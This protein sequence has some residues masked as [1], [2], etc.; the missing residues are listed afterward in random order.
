MKKIINFI[1]AIL[2]CGV[3]F[4]QISNTN[5]FKIGM[6]GA[7]FKEKTPCFGETWTTPL[8]NNGNKTS[9]LNVYKEDGF[10]IFQAYIPSEWSTPTGIK[11]MLSLAEANDLKICIHNGHYYKPYVD[12]A[13]NY[14][15]GNST[16]EYEDCGYVL[17]PCEN[18]YF[19]A[20]Y[21]H[22]RTNILDHINNIY[23]LPKYSK[24]IWGIVVAEESSIFHLFHSNPQC[25]GNIY[26]NPN[27]FVDVELPPSN[28][29][30]ASLYYKNHL[31][32]PFGITHIKSIILEANHEKT[33]FENTIDV[34][35]NHN[36]QEYIK[37]LDKN[38][39]RDLFFESSYTM[40][41]PRTKNDH[42]MDMY[43]NQRHYLG[44][45]KTINYALKYTK[46]VHKVIAIQDVDPDNIYHF[47]SDL[48]IK[49]ANWL[50]FQTYTSIIHGATG[51]WFWSIDQS[52]DDSEDN[53]EEGGEKRWKGS[54]ATLPNRFD[55][56]YFPNHYK[57][58]ISNLAKELRYLVNKNI[59]STDTSN[60]IGVK[61]DEADPMCIVP[62]SNIYIP[63][64]L[65]I[66]RQNENYGL[67]YT[68]RSNGT[69]VY[70]I[71]SNP[72][73][74]I[75]NNV[76]LNFSYCAN[77]VIRNSSSVSVLFENN[78]NG[79]SSSNYKIDR[80]SGID[81]LNNTIVSQYDLAIN[82]S[83]RKLFLSFGP[84]DVKVIK[85]NSNPIL[86]NPLGWKQE[87]TNNGN[88]YIGMKKIKDNDIFING[89]FDG[90]GKD[91]LLLIEYNSNSTSDNITLL[92]QTINDD[93]EMLWSNYGS[94]SCVLYPY[95]N[96]LLVGDFDGDG[97]DELIGNDFA[98]TTMFKFDN[99][100]WN[101]GWSDYGN[102]SHPIRPYKKLF[103]V[104]DFD[105]N[106]K[107][108]LLG[109]DLPG[110]FTTCFNFNGSDFTWG[111]S[112]YG[113][114]HPLFPYRRNL[115]VGD[116]NGDG[117][118]DLLG[119]NTFLTFFEFYNGDWNWG[120]SNYGA[121]NFNDWNYP[122]LTSDELLVGNIDND[123]K[124][125]II[126]IQN[127]T[128]ADKMT[129]MDFDFSQAFW[130]KNWF[131]DNST[132][133]KKIDNWSINPETSLNT[134]YILFKSKIGSS[135]RLFGIRKFCQNYL[136]SSYRTNLTSNYK[137]GGQV[138]FGHN[139]SLNLNNE[140]N[141]INLYPNPSNN[142]LINLHSDIKI[143]SYSIF[144]L[145]GKLIRSSKDNI[146]SFEDLIDFTTELNGIYII[147]VLLVNNDLWSKKIVIIK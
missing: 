70:M 64:S 12:A 32:I 121:Q 139:F 72:L 2:Y 4:S 140:T 53:S 138:N 126:L 50:W 11:S 74:I 76:E 105:G 47:H 123:P 35:G 89:D 111:W 147:K 37:L 18:S 125:E 45:F 54:K 84:L 21:P 90:D 131:V 99:G 5:E 144:S 130:N 68:I 80:N 66:E 39:S 10:N 93:W 101:W 49:N 44:P 77:E 107:D 51:I 117:K 122:F 103:Y 85:F 19:A 142:G 129:T 94:S 13:G 43:N 58:F 42:Y 109:C 73:D 104:G 33:I 25:R 59:L 60:I 118:D 52:W 116:F 106:G 78:T 88:G 133:I 115:K 120:W 61:T 6:Y 141:K 17:G 98:F 83:T 128:I 124:E 145:D 87:W 63:N 65:P 69:D 27:Y 71:I 97:K 56:Q 41:L 134:K 36:P 8:D 23:S 48:N 119:V 1:I 22:F 143:N 16:N 24:T 75:L 146:N 135:E 112:D 79:V 38:D 31:S 136:V 132:T 46:E 57:N 7:Y 137:Y 113:I 95:R 34:F 67:R 108:D 29:L 100:V 9:T 110:G 102:N 114:N 62:P 81:L 127:S 40:F 28:V 92:T 3:L 15:E 82:S 30:D 14:I 26:G 86:R 91:D 96:N 55:R 20:P